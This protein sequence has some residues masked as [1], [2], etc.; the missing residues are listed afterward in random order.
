MG[1]M[2]KSF[3][4]NQPSISMNVIGFGQA[5]SRIADE[6]ASFKNRQGDTVY[7]CFALNSTS[8]DLTGLKNIPLEHRFDLDIG[9]MGKNPEKGVELLENHEEFKRIVLEEFPY[10]RELILFIAGLGGGTGTSTIV[11]AIEEY[12]EN[13]FKPAINKTFEKIVQQVGEITVRKNPEKFAKQAV[14][15]VKENMPSIGLIV[16][17]PLRADGA[18]TLR[19]VSKFANK[20]WNLANDVTS[21]VSFVIF[22]DNQYFYDKFHSNPPHLR[23]GAHNYRDFANKIISQTFHEINTASNGEGSDVMFDRV[24]FRRILLE[25]QGSLVINRVS[26]PVDKIQKSSDLEDMLLESM[27]GSIFHEPIQLINER[28]GVKE[29]TEIYHV[30]LMAVIDK[31]KAISSNFLDETKVKIAESDLYITGSVFTG[32]LQEK[33]DFEATVYT[34]YKSNGLPTRLAKG[35]VEEY[36]EYMEKKKSVKTVNSSIQ[37]IDAE[38]SMDFDLDIASLGLNIKMDEKEENKKD[39]K[40]NDV[41]EMLKDVDFS[42]LF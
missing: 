4:E 38:D 3:I 22:A 36:H 15:I 39:Q 17:L 8:G 35:L 9:G 12:S 29:S 7:N 1:R 5:G 25:R 23:M 11:K 34:F 14:R 10:D 42:K 33:N 2:V 6:F 13:K 28:N 18:D 20:L 32:Y 37:T 41:A 30:G 16:T 24:D 40:N 21:G 31:N 27:T 19:Q 26:C